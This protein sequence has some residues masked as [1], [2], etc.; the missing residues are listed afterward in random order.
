MP[1][2]Q[3][4]ERI[5]PLLVF[6]AAVFAYWRFEALDSVGISSGFHQ[7][8]MPYRKEISDIGRLRWLREW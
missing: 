4:T 6:I 8:G 1:F 3:A 7:K 2:F 5:A